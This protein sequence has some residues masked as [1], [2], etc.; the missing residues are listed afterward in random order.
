MIHGISHE[1]LPELDDEFVK[2]TS[3]FE[4]VD[5]LKADIRK[6]LEESAKNAADQGFQNAL[7]EQL[8][9]KV[10]EPVPH[11]MFERRADILLNQFAEQLQQQ[12]V[13]LDMYLQYTGMDQDSLKATYL[14]RAEGEVKLRLALES[15]AKQESLEVQDEELEE[16]L[17]KIADAYKLQVEQIR[18][19]IS[20]DVRTDLLVQKAL[21]LVKDAATPIDA[22]EE[23]K[24]AEAETEEAAAE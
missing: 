23:E 24:Q 10:T 2:D 3:E 9:E 19:T 17:Q 16:E 21:D 14:E 7:I 4:T 13:S 11:V 6:K 8:I 12:G 1:E 18:P 22:P 15:I 5:E 20:D